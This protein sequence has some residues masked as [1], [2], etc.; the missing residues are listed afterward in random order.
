MTSIATTLTL[1]PKE[2]P[3]DDH[4]PFGTIFTDH[5][6]VM[7]YDEGQG[8]HDAKIVPYG[9]FSLDP[10]CATLHYA[11]SV[12]D[13]LKAFR[14]KDG[15]VRLF[16]PRAH[17]ER[18]GRSSER[19]CI[20]QIDPETVVDSFRKLIAVDRAWVPSKPGTALGIT[21]MTMA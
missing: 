21:R 8:W 17:A 5:M 7:D 15:T 9:P 10:A 3:S 11:Q 4:L 16:R 2:R 1:K 12:F 19:M 6:F 14:G 18:L 20:P 13:G